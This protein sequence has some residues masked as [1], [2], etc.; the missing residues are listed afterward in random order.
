MKLAT[1]AQRFVIREARQEDIKGI[2]KIAKLLALVDGSSRPQGLG[3]LVSNYNESHYHGLVSSDNVLL[4]VAEDRKNKKIVGFVVAHLVSKENV[5]SID[6]SI[7]LIL[8]RLKVG[9]FVYIKQVAVDPEYMGQGIGTKLYDVLIQEAKARGENL[10]FA[11]IVDAPPNVAS[12]AFHIK[13]GFVKILEYFPKPDPDGRARRRS[14]WG[15]VDGASSPWEIFFER[16]KDESS[17]IVEYLQVV[18]D[19]YM[20]EDNL[21][22]T[23]LGRYISFMFALVAALFHVAWNMKNFQLSLFIAILG[24]FVNWLFSQKIA[25]GVKYMLAHKQT[26]TQ[27]D[28]VIA[29]RL[30]MVGTMNKATLGVSKTVLL[31]SFVPRLGLVLWAA[32]VLLSLY[33]I[34]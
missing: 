27:L 31:L 18:A 23:K 26:L 6:D 14:I 5:P 33:H 30:N 12:Y 29:S 34:M 11:T 4:F 24:F 2:H 17:W 9:R 3:F 10:F 22:W 16:G 15:R 7:S 28:A 32:Y 21:N 13:M 25:S 19:L 20:H 1:C 8:A